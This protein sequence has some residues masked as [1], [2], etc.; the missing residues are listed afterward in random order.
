MVTFNFVGF[1]KERNWVTRCHHYSAMRLFGKRRLLCCRPRSN[2]G[3]RKSGIEACKPNA[4]RFGGGVI[5]ITQNMALRAGM[6]PDC[7]FTSPV[8]LLLGGSGPKRK[9]WK[10][11]CCKRCLLTAALGEVWK[12]SQ[13]AKGK[14]T[15]YKGPDCVCALQCWQGKGAALTLVVVTGFQAQ[16]W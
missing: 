9:Q 14:G 3:Y 16:Y 1:V 4:Q 12:V 11:G 8:C 5:I 10:D 6:Y 13:W 15:S 2:Q 7:A